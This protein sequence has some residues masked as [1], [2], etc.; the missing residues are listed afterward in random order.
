M[1]RP[2]A[3]NLWQ[4]KFHWAIWQQVHCKISLRPNYLTRCHISDKAKAELN[5]TGISWE[6]PELDILLK[7]I[8]GQIEE[9]SHSFDAAKNRRLKRNK[10]IRKKIDN[11]LRRKFAWRDQQKPKKI[12][13]F[14]ERDH[15]IFK[16][17]IW[18]KYKKLQTAPPT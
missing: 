5:A 1:W 3:E 17:K 12:Q 4:F 7:K 14:W 9:L 8:L 15:L 16:R 10:N 6:L 13:I 2:P 11:R 18:T